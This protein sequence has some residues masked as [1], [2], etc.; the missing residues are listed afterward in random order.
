MEQDLSRCHLCRKKWGGGGN[1]RVEANRVS[2]WGVTHHER[3]SGCSWGFL[4]PLQCRMSCPWG[5]SVENKKKVSVCDFA[6]HN[7]A[8]RGAHEPSLDSLTAS[9]KY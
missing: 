5:L 4:T 2:R 8:E 7:R 1:E 9:T 6:T 3:P